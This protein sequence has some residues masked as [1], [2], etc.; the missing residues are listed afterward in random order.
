[1]QTLKITMAKKIGLALSGGAAR[2]IAHIGVLEALNEAGVYP[3][4][5]AGTSAGALIASLYADGHNSKEM[6]KI[7]AK[8]KFFNLLK[9]SWPKGGMMSTE[10]LEKLMN[11]NLKAKNFSDLK[12]PLFVN[13]VNLN[14]G[15][16]VF[17]DKGD[18][19]QKVI[20]SSALPFI[21]QPVK[22]GHHL[23]VDG[24][25]LVNLPVDP[26]LKECD[27]IIGVN[28]N[29]TGEKHD[30]SSVFSVALRSYYLALR[31]NVKERQKQCDIFIEL[32]ALEEFSHFDARKGK[33][34]YEIGYFATREILNTPKVKKQLESFR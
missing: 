31:N 18:L 10:K 8:V 23:F 5:I 16:T 29:P 30:F 32:A 22:I 24:G 15:E 7:F 9:V 33:E 11:E 27:F 6:L 3:D 34:M 12:I 25:L 2:G 20:A 17:F 19:V 26:L 1:M 14:K 28:L 4:V 13:A 21:Y